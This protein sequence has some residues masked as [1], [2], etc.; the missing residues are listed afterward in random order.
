MKQDV[1]LYINDRIV[2]FS[3][4]LSMPFTYQL[5][6]FNNPTIVKNTFSKTI[7]IVGT[8]NN[9]TIFGEIYNFDREQLYDNSYILGAYFNPSN[10][11]P[12]QIFRDG[13]IIESGYMQLNTITMNKKVINYN[14]TL[15]G[16]IGDFFYK[17]MYNDDSEPLTLADLQYFVE[18]DVTG[19]VL[20]NDTEM[21]FRINRFF[22]SKCWEQLY[23]E[24]EG[25]YIYNYINF[26]PM[27]NGLYDNFD[28]DKFLI[29]A[30][31]ISSLTTATTVTI[32]DEE[33]TDYNGYLLGV[34]ENKHDEWVMRDLRSYAQRPVLK[35]SKFIS[36]ICNPKNNGGYKVVLDEDFFNAGNPY[37]NKA[38]ITL[39]L[40]STLY[41]NSDD[42]EL[43]NTTTADVIVANPDGVKNIDEDNPTGSTMLATTGST[44]II[45][46]INNLIDISSLPQT[47][48]LSGKLSFQ[49][50]FKPDATTNLPDVLYIA[51]RIY[52]NA[53]TEPKVDKYLFSSI[54]L[55]LVAKNLNGDII[56]RSSL[57]NFTNSVNDVVDS[58]IDEDAPIYNIL[59]SWYNVDGTYYFISDENNN[60]FEIDINNILKRGDAFT[61]ELVVKKITKRYGIDYYSF[62]SMGG[63]STNTN[64]KL[65]YDWQYSPTL[66]YPDNTIY[67]GN[68]NVLVADDATLTAKWSDTPIQTNQRISKDKLLKTEKT[69]ADY[70]LS[71]SKLFGL[72]YEKDIATKTIYIKQRNNF[73]TGDVINWEDRIDYNNQVTITPILFDK[74][75][76]TMNLEEED[77]VYF[78]TKYKNEYGVNY[79]QKRINTNY[80]FNND[81]TEIYKDNVY[82]NA[83][84]VT[85][86]SPY[87]RTF[88][89]EDG[90]E[91]YAY[92]AD[93][94]ELQY[95]RTNEDDEIKTHAINIKGKNLYSRKLTKDWNNQSG[96]DMFTKICN[97]TKENDEKSLVETSSSLVFLDGFSNLLTSDDTPVNYYLTDDLP[98]MITLN[99]NPTYIYTTDE[100]GKH[101]ENVGIKQTTLPH[102][103][104]YIIKGGNVVNSWDFGVPKENYIININYDDSTTL[105]SNYWSSFYD[106]QLSINTK[107]VTANVN[108]QGVN[109]NQSLL[110][111]F[112]Y[113]GG[114]NWLLNKIDNYD[115]NTNK[116]TKCEFIKVGNT[117]NYTKDIGVYGTYFKLSSNYVILPY[118]AT[119]ATIHLS[120]SEE[121]DISTIPNEIISIS[122][123]TGLAG[124]YNI[125][126]GLRE[127]NTTNNDKR[128]SLR[129]GNNKQIIFIQLPNPTTTARITGIVKYSNNGIIPNARLVIEGTS[130]DLLRATNPNDYDGSYMFYVPIGVEVLIEIQTTNSETIYSV[131]NTFN[132]DE[133]YDIYVPTEE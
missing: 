108:L 60:T 56:A 62:T 78:L 25:N 9:N 47:T 69:P 17:L 27:Q 107:K 71:Y 35:F 86:T 92:I 38:Y 130:V 93:G 23:N 11:T 104:R 101:G 7:T 70:L 102:F 122:N 127:Q 48:V 57:Y 65:V 44:E 81:T 21:D 74:K 132:E 33:Y 59:G 50:S 98:E 128:F 31:D 115:I 103:S 121:W 99:E 4:E 131:T 19:E 55:E 40:L 80:N 6:D 66:S 34:I 112:Y 117:Y 24:R 100:F 119:T 29:N 12:F 75:F 54:A 85:D 20:P 51:N 105:Y 53:K 89:N 43:Y 15:Y 68:W 87:Y 46:T 32:D 114:C 94:F 106:E 82:R 79:G 30:K 95:F 73:F 64:I 1:R 116:T 45:S 129:F 16:G 36:A 76:Y 111:N 110:K 39:P 58:T 113:F 97:Y 124:E 118:S 72:Y 96:Y 13:E 61:Y 41:Q 77:D 123:T 3:N 63:M 83:I 2:D 126:F 120:T 90:G 125:T 88:Y 91:V 42:D 52:N 10:R 84:E 22:V 5:E 18:D 133:K 109:V 28:S 14:C 37:Y 8:P 49:L 67:T 26:A